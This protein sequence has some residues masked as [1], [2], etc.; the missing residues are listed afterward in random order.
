MLEEV[1][2]LLAAGSVLPSPF[3]GVQFHR[4]VVADV[5]HAIA[6]HRAAVGT[7][8]REGHLVAIDL[9]DLGRER[10]QAAVSVRKPVDHLAD[11]DPGHLGLGGPVVL[12]RLR[13]LRLL[14]QDLLDEF[15]LAR[16]LLGRLLLRL[17]RRGHP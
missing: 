7:H 10:G 17:G 16:L 15:V 4:L 11:F 14:L 2:L 13:L 12:S 5:W 6:G 1:D 8:D 3:I 9:E